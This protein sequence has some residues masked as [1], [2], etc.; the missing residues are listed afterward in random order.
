MS[1]NNLAPLLLLLL[2]TSLTWAI[3]GRFSMKYL[4]YNSNINKQYAN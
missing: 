3:I 1:D 4:Y 2:L